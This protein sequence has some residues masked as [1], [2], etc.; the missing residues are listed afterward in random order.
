MILPSFY[1]HTSAIKNKL[2]LGR[3]VNKWDRFY[4]R[5]KD[6][7]DYSRVVRVKFQKRKQHV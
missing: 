3:K 4:V 7:W 1:T 6:K 2:I 5:Y